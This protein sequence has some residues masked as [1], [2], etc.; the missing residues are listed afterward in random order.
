MSVHRGGVAVVVVTGDSDRARSHTH[1]HLILARVKAAVAPRVAII[2]HTGAIVTGAMSM[3]VH[4]V[5]GA[6]GGA[7]QQLRDEA[8]AVG[9]GV[10]RATLALAIATHPKGRVALVVGRA[11]AVARHIL[12]TLG[13]CNGRDKEEGEEEE[14]K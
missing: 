9:A 7:V 8:R 5:A 13:T 14:A 11:S 4:A 10:A 1:T 3:T 2:A 6:G 12:A